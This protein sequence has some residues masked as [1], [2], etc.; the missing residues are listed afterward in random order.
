MASESPQSS[1][2]SGGAHPRT[3][4]DIIQSSTRYLEEHAVD[5]PRLTAELL[6]GHALRCRRLELY[7]RFDHVLPEPVLSRMRNGLSRLGKGEPLQYVLGNADFMGIHLKTDSRALIP[8][9]ETEGLVERVLGQQLLWA[10]PT[11]IIADVC[12]GS[13]CIAIAV[14]MK[15]PGSRIMAIDRSPEAVALARENIQSVL[16]SKEH[17]IEAVEGDLLE[18]VAP[19]SLDAVISNPPYI[20]SG[21]CDGLPRHI[22][23]YEPRMAL[24][25]GREGLDVIR[26]LVP[27]AFQ[28]LK[29]GGWIFMEIG[30]DQGAAVRP[31][32][33]DFT[34]VRI[35]TDLSGRDR[36]V[37][38]RRP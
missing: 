38:A 16:A 8:R 4:L 34:E 3:L 32:L 35:E 22:R 14:A 25:G 31:L 9:P 2:T 33:A 1:A 19:L 15:Q 36:Y 20:A 24:D 10:Q 17:F 30:F 12:T 37:I 7:L 18:G 6:A 23:D 29:A 13:G 28:A 21:V 5:Q 11:P 27:Q 26:R